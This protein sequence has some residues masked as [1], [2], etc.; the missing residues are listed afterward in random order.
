MDTCDSA[1]FA[2]PTGAP[3][4]FQREATLDGKWMFTWQPPA[5]Q[6]QNGNLTGYNFSCYPPPS[7]RVLQDGYSIITLTYITVDIIQEENYTCSVAARTAQGEGPATS[8][9]F[10]LSDGAVESGTDTCPP[11][12]QVYLYSLGGVAAILLVLCIILSVSFM[13]YRRSRRQDQK[14]K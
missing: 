9:Q 7:A 13:I 14:R 10:S 3:Q 5:T 2:V 1:F 11:D 4:N 8:L 6:S 12:L